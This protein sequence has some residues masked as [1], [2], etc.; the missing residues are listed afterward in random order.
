MTTHTFDS[1]ESWL[2]SLL[3]RFELLFNQ[4]LL[5]RGSFHVAL[6][7]GSTPKELYG[8]LNARGLDWS[9]II[10]WLGDERWVKP[11]HDDSNEKMIRSSL[12]LGISP[13]LFQS[14]HTAED[15][16]EAAALYETE[17]IKQLGPQP[18]IDLVLLGIGTDGHTASLFPGTEA[19]KEKNRYAVSN[20]VPQLNTTRVTLTY[21]ALNIAHETWFLVKG[22]DKAVMVDRLLQR[23][24]TI[25]SACI[26]AKNQQLFWWK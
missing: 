11:E 18:E 16:S 19:L 20:L 22:A 5:K 7:G 2:E 4:A 9:K 15:P 21:P 14:W 1:R 10:W 3:E 26:K 25:P 13:F 12:G 6:S 24:Q 23:D 17:L 8:A